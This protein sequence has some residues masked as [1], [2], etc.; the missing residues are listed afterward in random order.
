[1]SADCM[2]MREFA[3]TYAICMAARAK[4]ERRIQRRQEVL[5]AFESSLESAPEMSFECLFESRATKSRKTMPPTASD[6]KVSVAPRNNTERK[7]KIWRRRAIKM[8][9]V[10]ATVKGI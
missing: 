1:M 5:S 4:A 8:N 9:Q 6:W 2:R 7:P 3:R 10:R